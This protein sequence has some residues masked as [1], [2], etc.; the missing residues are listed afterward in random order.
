MLKGLFKRP[1]TAQVEGAPQSPPG[2]ELIKL[3]VREYCLHR[4]ICLKKLIHMLEREI[5]YLVLEEARGN[6]RAAAEML[7]LRP[8]T[9]HYKIQRMGLVPVHKYLM[10]EDVQAAG[11]TV[12][13][14]SAARPDRRAH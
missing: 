9:L 3:Y 10:V 12:Q 11:E 7:G 14:G 4:R 5:I 6:Q 8:N 1:P 13:P 2:E